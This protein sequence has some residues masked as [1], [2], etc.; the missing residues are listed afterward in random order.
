MDDGRL[1]AQFL[2]KGALTWEDSYLD[3]V[4]KRDKFTFDWN[5]VSLAFKAVGYASE[6]ER[7]DV[8]DEFKFSLSN[9]SSKWSEKRKLF[10]YANDEDFWAAFTND[11][12]SDSYYYI[13]ECKA[14]NIPGFASLFSNKVECYV[15]W[16]KVLELLVDHVG[17]RTSMNEFIYFIAGDKSAK[18]Y[19]VNPVIAFGEFSDGF[20]EG[21]QKIAKS[22]FDHLKVDDAHQLERK[23][24]MRTALADI[25]GEDHT[26]SPFVWVVSQGAKLFKKY[27]EHYDNYTH[28]FSVNKLLTEIEEKNL[29][30]TNKINDFITG[31]QT[32]AFALPG[33]LVGI[34]ALVKSAGMAEMALICVGLMMVRS[35]TKTANDIYFDS[36]DNLLIQIKK[37]FEKYKKTEVAEEV[38]ESAEDTQSK[39][40]GL[41]S[42]AK[43]RLEYIDKVAY[44][45]LLSGF[46]FLAYKLYL[47]P[48]NTAA[49]IFFASVWADFVSLSLYVKSM[50]LSSWQL[51]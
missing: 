28:R 42:K 7:E 3:I 41:I 22:L 1:V 39:I 5:E 45:M 17:T 30:Y 36:F 16:R 37:G 51:I 31:S 40:E 38:K 44:V 19:E 8:G 4:I 11:A 34:A 50:V 2:E 15:I 35:L 18:K 49:K 13:T 29:E 48:D 12:N 26:G 20:D 46:S 14:T 21:L 24:V 25:L 32:K 27:R 23:S 47:A 10:F 6:I 33:V 9:E 43:K